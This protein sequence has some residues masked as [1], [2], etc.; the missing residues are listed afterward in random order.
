MDIKKSCNG[1]GDN[2]S[3]KD[4]YHGKKC[5]INKRIIRDY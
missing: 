2:V 1:Y 5:S 4:Y 3:Y